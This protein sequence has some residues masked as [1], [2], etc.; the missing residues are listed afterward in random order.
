MKSPESIELYNKLLD[1]GLSE[2]FSNLISTELNTTWT[3]TRMLGY[4]RYMPHLREEDIVDEML[5][6]LSDR[7]QIRQKHE[8]E[9]NQSLINDLYNSDIFDE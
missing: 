2:Q 8:L 6:I 1:R 4:L 9:H 7:E 5:A 3:A